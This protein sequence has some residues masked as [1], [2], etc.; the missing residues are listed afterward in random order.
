M[1][2]TLTHALSATIAAGITYL[3]VSTLAP[4]AALIPA[5]TA[6][7]AEN[8]AIARAVGLCFHKVGR[9]DEATIN[10]ATTAWL[11]ANGTD[12]SLAWSRATPKVIA[13]AARIQSRLGSNCKSLPDA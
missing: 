12:P 7:Q 6:D 9:A 3:T 5:P 13:R 11:Q 2:P 8:A 10:A 4:T 1:K